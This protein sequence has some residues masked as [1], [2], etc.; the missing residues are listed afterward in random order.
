MSTATTSRFRIQIGSPDNLHEI[1][2]SA[3]QDLKNHFD[4]I[5]KGLE[6]IPGVPG[7][8]IYGAVTLRGLSLKPKIFESWFLTEY[9]SV[10]QG[11][12]DKG[13]KELLAS[14]ISKINEEQECLACA[15]YHSAAAKFEG[16]SDDDLSIIENYEAEKHK[17]PSIKRDIIDFG[18][19]SAFQPKKI[20]DEDVKRIKDHGI[21]DKG[22]VEIV[23]SALIA[24]NL[25]AFN[26]VFNLQEGAE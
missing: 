7:E 21:S 10:K 17:L 6:T 24:Y 16:A 5:K 23:S 19:K 18:I 14:I 9:H 15:P 25:S 3:P 1:E 8:A 4:L 2:K 11:E 12:V 13:T 20:T 22:L 26:Q